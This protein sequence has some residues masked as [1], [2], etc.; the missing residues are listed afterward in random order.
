[1][2]VLFLHRFFPA[3]YRHLAAAL[4]ADP[5]NEVRF[6]AAEREADSA[7]PGVTSHL[8][9]PARAAHAST[10]HYLQFA[11][12]A[13]LHGQAA[14]R[15]MRELAKEGFRPDVI[16][17]HVGFGAGLFA[18][19]AFPQAPILAYA[20]WYY[21]A[22]DSDADYLDPAGVGDD[23][24]CRL[25]LRNAAILT[26]LAA[27]QAVICPTAFQRDQFPPGLRE[28]ITVL[29]DGIDTGYFAP[30]GER[31]VLDLPIPAN[32]PI[33]TYA[34]R[35]LD[36]YRGFPQ[37]MRMAALLQSRRPDLHVVVAGED[38]VFYGAAPPG[39]ST[40]K[41]A[42]LAELGTLDPARLHF[43]GPLPYDRYR[44]L[45]RASS[46][47]VYLTVP[48][49]LSWS[50]LE[51]MATGCAIV[52]SDTAPVR[53]F[54][55][56]DSEGILVDVF[57]PPAIAAGVERLLAGDAPVA[58]MR[59]RARAAMVT[60]AAITNLLPRQIDLLR[61]VARAR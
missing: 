36:P 7:I 51:A 42:M 18:A 37:F 39:G 26:E 23:D 25:R 59:R 8:Y 15:A 61:A 53:E 43:L 46:A 56:S 24:A 19:D 33:V 6:I 60:R 3:Q 12:N 50:L 41:A 5:A 40:W 20:E 31:A 38:R 48:F 11:E 13:V 32:A 17:A 34:T 58:E 21:R 9:K 2:K 57:S 45:L 52:A 35:G 47:H 22:R 10:H 27:A 14:F 54:I 28:R 4:A 30:A 1:M 55:A 49:V 16:C 29:H 44:T